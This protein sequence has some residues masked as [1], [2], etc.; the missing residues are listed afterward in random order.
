MPRGVLSFLSEAREASGSENGANRSISSSEKN[1]GSRFEG[2]LK[3]EFASK[4]LPR[5]QKPANSIT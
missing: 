4:Q 3:I 2:I 1:H 5:G